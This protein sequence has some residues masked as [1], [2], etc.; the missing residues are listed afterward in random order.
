MQLQWTRLR[1]RLRKTHES[2]LPTRSNP[3]RCD[4]FATWLGSYRERLEEICKSAEAGKSGSKE[5]KGEI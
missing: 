3:N 5:T 2:A 1:N 4:G